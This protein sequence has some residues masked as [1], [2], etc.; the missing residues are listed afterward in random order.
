[1]E[2][3]ATR[4]VLVGL[5]FEPHPP[6]DP[7]DDPSLRP[8]PCAHYYDR[9]RRVAHPSVRCVFDWL[10]SEPFLA[11]VAGRLERLEGAPWQPRAL[12]RR[13]TLRRALCLRPLT[14]LRRLTVSSMHAR[15][16]LACWVLAA[17]ERAGPTLPAEP[18]CVRNQSST[19]ATAIAA[20]PASCTFFM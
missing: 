17:C 11:R 15:R 9:H 7:I 20:F 4:C 12:K 13:E 6:V 18:A 14:Q 10:S 16:A 2:F 3:L 1:M 5:A 19:P 8:P